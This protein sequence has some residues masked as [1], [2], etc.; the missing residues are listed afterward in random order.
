M[1]THTPLGSPPPPQ[2]PSPCPPRGQARVLVSLGLQGC[3]QVASAS[4]AGCRRG[5]AQGP[6]RRPWRRAGCSL[7]CAGLAGPGPRWGPRPS[8]SSCRSR[9][10]GRHSRCWVLDSC[11]GPCTTPT[12]GPAP[13][14]SV[15]EQTLQPRAAGTRLPATMHCVP[16]TLEHRKPR[17]PPP[18]HQRTST[19]ATALPGELGPDTRPPDRPP[20]KLRDD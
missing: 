19:S 7:P 13:T 2:P 1:G 14:E 15:R 8:Q 5:G 12:A 9:S 6:G 10:C 18:Y 17:H 20:A 11:P 3:L 4:G 16:P